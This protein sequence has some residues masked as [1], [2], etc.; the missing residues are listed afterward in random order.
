MIDLPPQFGP[1][2][3][4]DSKVERNQNVEKRHTI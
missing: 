3:M 1:V 2:H 4:F